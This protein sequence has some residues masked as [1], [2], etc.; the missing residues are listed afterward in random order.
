[1]IFDRKRYEKLV[2][3]KKTWY[4]K[5][6]PIFCHVIDKEVHFNSKGFNHLFYDGTGKGRSNQ[7]RIYRLNLLPLAIPVIKKTNTIVKYKKEFTKSLGREVEYW[8]IKETVGKSDAIV[9]VILRRIGT[10]NVTFH[11][12]FKRKNTKKAARKRLP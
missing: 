2:T 7:E 9:T 1:M 10:G 11:S 5:L 8:R 4:K 6:K 3:D 12:I